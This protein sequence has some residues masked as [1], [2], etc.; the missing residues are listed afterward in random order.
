MNPEI[1]YI[2]LKSGFSDNGPAWIGLAKFSKTGNTIYFNGLAFKKYNGISGNYIEFETGDEYWISG[3]K[4]DMTDRHRA[5]GGF[6]FVEER[7]L[8]DYLK[9]INRSALDKTKYKIVEVNTASPIKRIHAVENEID[10]AE[11]DNLLIHRPANEL[12]S[13]Q[14]MNAVNYLIGKEKNARF[15]KGRRTWKEL[16]I[17]FEA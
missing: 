7:I 15:N 11:F 1:R 6:I 17:N 3:I 10:I 9:L 2:E 16:R 4:K 13:D 8:D 12:S 14:L 5:G